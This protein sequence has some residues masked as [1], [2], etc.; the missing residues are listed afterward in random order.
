MIC[1][2]FTRLCKSKKAKFVRFF[3]FLRSYSCWL[4]SYNNTVAEK[5][6]T[7]TAVIVNTVRILREGGKQKNKKRIT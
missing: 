1:S 2:S 4:L 6:F 5:D 7:G 3:S